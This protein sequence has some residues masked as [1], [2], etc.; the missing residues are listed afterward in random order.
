MTVERYIVSA[1]VKDVARKP[2]VAR[3]HIIDRG[4]PTQRTELEHE[5]LGWWITV[6]DMSLYLGTSTE[7]PIIQ[8]GDSVKIIIEKTDA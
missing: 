1:T 8:A 4:L 2:R 5:D 6:G 3:G 7:Q